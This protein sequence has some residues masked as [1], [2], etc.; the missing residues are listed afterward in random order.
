MYIYKFT[1]G[2]EHPFIGPEPAYG[3]S[4]GVAKKAVRDWT[5]RKHKK[6]WGVHNWTQE[7]QSDS[8]K[9]LCHKNEGSVIKVKQRP[10]KMDDRTTYRTLSTKRAPSQIGID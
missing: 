5:N 6:Y 3:I 7:R 10:V 4:T 1:T 2:S 9:A 8:Y